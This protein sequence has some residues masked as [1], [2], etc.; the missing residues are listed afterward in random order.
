MLYHICRVL[1]RLINFVFFQRIEFPLPPNLKGP[2]VFTSNHPNMF[3]DVVVIGPYLPGKV[4]FI[5]KSALFK[6]PFM[7]ALLKQ[8]GVI[9]VYRKEH[10]E[11]GDNQSAFRKVVEALERHETIV[12]F[13]EGTSHAKDSLLPLK[14]GAARMAFEAEELHQFQL[15]V[16]IVPLG[17]HFSQREQFRSKVLVRVGEPIF[18]KEYQKEYE[19]DPKNGVSV[20]T[21]E[22]YTRMKKVTLNLIDENEGK[23]LRQLVQTYQNLVSDVPTQSLQEM[24]EMRDA[25]LEAYRWHKIHR[26]KE[27]QELSRKVSSFLNATEKFEVQ[28]RHLAKPYE[29]SKVFKYSYLRLPI[30]AL[31]A[32]LYFCGLVFHYLPYRIPGIIA[33]RLED[34]TEKGTSKLLWGMFL[35]PFFYA[36]YWGV[37]CYFFSWKIAS[38]LIL[39]LP[40]LGIYSLLYLDAL[41]PF[42]R[43][44]F[45]FFKLNWHQKERNQLRIMSEAIQEEWLRLQKEYIHSQLSRSTEESRI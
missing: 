3:L 39:V 19:E 22:L 41:V 16:Q 31:G 6:N 14:T 43:N 34:L 27:I 7:G 20:L 11:Q 42:V 40:L 36:I 45:T 26:P 32:P 24:I 35:F 10:G 13:P 9:P 18:A 37:A 30:L 23:E 33:S 21:E 17:L 15:G 2:L 29:F 44:M 28:S 1:I 8:L 38:L 4:H 25:I 5:A 12:I